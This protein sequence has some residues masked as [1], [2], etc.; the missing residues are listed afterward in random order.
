MVQA[1]RVA[2]RR[3]RSREMDKDSPRAGAVRVQK[4]RALP[5]RTN[6]RACQKVAAPGPAA[7]SCVSLAV[8]GGA[9]PGREHPM[10]DTECAAGRWAVA[11][12]RS[13]RGSWRSRSRGRTTAGPAARGRA[14][15][16]RARRDLA[17]GA[18]ADDPAR[19]GPAQGNLERLQQFRSTGTAL[20]IETVPQ[21]GP[22]RRRAPPQPR[23][24]QAAGGLQDRALRGGARR[25]AHGGRR[26]T[27]WCF[28]GT[29]KTRVWAVTDR[30][31]R[32]RGRRGEGLR[33]LRRASACRTALCFSPDG[34]LYVV[35]HNRVLVFPAAEFFYESPDVA[36]GVGGRRRAS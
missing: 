7:L 21:E 20:Q 12:R 35:E 11:V 16:R 9:G 5:G 26:R 1:P 18:A 32:P 30:D 24:H 23:A 22:A 15:R 31:Q 2:H 17:V 28:V 8:I 4:W 10:R 13:R 33:A 29:R 3:A 27:A 14:R 6:S 19:G 34:F 25:A 36:V